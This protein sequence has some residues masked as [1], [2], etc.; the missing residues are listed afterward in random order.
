MTPRPSRPSQTRV[1]GGGLV[2]SPSVVLHVRHGGLAAALSVNVFGDVWAREAPPPLRDPTR[3]SE[4][5]LSLDQAKAAF[6][7]VR[8]FRGGGEVGNGGDAFGGLCS[9]VHA[10]LVVG[11]ALVTATRGGLA[12]M[13]EEASTGGIVRR[14]GRW[15]LHEKDEPTHLFPASVRFFL[16]PLVYAFWVRLTG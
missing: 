2:L 13:V 9:R 5:V 1:G 10:R 15:P 3:H 14:G 7:A 6:L 8:F 4:V 16:S 11:A 12:C